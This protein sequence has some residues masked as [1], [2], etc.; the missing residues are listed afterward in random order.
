MLFNAFLE[1]LLPDTRAMH[2]TEMDWL[3]LRR[4]FVTSQVIPAFGR[5]EETQRGGRRLT[6]LKTLQGSH[7]I[8]RSE[9]VQDAIGRMFGLI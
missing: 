2:S 1:L 5:L 7:D 6:L 9:G 8:L 4:G 3:A